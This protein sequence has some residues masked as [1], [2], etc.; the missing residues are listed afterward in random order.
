MSRKARALGALQERLLARTQFVDRALQSVEDGLLIADAAGRIAFANPRAA[1]ILGLG[2]RSLLG[3]NLFDRLSEIEYGADSPAADRAGALSRLLHDRVAIEREIVVGTAEP[4][5]YTLRMA[6]VSDDSGGLGAPL[7]V[8]AT[9]S[10]VTKQR[11]LQRMQNDV[12]RLVTHEMRTP[13]TAIKGM[14]EVMMKFDP[15]AEK[16]REMNAAVNEAT[17]RMTR[18]IDDYLD[19]TRLES[20]A[21]EPDWLG[22]RS[23]R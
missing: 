9:L 1:N 10:D 19:L 4:R 18:M 22:A 23:N 7:G 12:M 13:L 8:V 11:E 5:Y 15:G 17:E 2:Q 6:A 16:R 3:S 20:G 21:R 14:S